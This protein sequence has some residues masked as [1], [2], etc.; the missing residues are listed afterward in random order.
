MVALNEAIDA[1]VVTKRRYPLL[2]AIA[3]E[4]DKLMGRLS[5]KKIGRRRVRI[6]ND[7]VLQL[8]RDS[9]DMFVIDLFS[10]RER[11]VRRGLFNL[12]EEDCARLRRCDP[13]EIP[14][15]PAMIHG[16]IGGPED[17][18]RI[19]AEVQQ[20][21]RELVA[22]SI[23]GALDRLIPGEYPVMPKGVQA[24]VRRFMKETEPLDRDRN[25]VRAHRYERHFDS[26]HFQSLGELQGQLDIFERLLGDLYL[27]LTRNVFM[28]QLDFHADSEGAAEDLADIMVHGSINSAVNAYG[29]A[30]KTNKNPVPWYYF[31]R[32]KFFES[33]SESK[34]G[35]G[36]G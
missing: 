24:L 1:Y 16:D 9:F 27:V 11:L 8:A 17:Y 28:F 21:H 20:H 32:R 5:E 22:Q 4:L 6:W 29:V 30:R 35:G 36:G 25:R 31:H 26:Q 18:A 19:Q 33:P 12:L 14:T 3:K 2:L 7:A 34:E 10:L 13:L 15:R 23:N